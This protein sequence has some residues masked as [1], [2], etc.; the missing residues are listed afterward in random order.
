MEISSNSQRL[1]SFPAGN[2]N[3]LRYQLDNQF[4]SSVSNGISVQK[5]HLLQLAEGFNATY[6]NAMLDV[7]Y[8]DSTLE[9]VIFYQVG[10]TSIPQMYS[11]LLARI[12]DAGELFQRLEFSELSGNQKIHDGENYAVLLA[13]FSDPEWYS[14]DISACS[15]PYPGLTANGDGFIYC[16]NG[17]RVLAGVVDGL[18]HGEAAE[19]AQRLA[20]DTLQANSGAP[21]RELFSSVHRALRST[22]GAAM[23]LAIVDSQ[24][25]CVECAGVGNVELRM[26]HRQAN[27]LPTAGVLGMGTF[28]APVE[29]RSPWSNDSVL[30]MYSDGISGRWSMGELAQSSSSSRLMCH[31]LLRRYAK[32]N[33]DAT[34]LVI[35]GDGRDD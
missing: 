35:R 8:K 15:R 32:Q 25:G 3:A 30:V 34:V 33:D 13:E 9:S 4:S 2:L 1:I 19:E 21:L 31:M 20:L 29:R 28:K 18:G 10:G 16:Q 22:R 26:T 17:S 14:S 24:A 12:R 27:Y 23:T 6:P 11:P 5:Q 7:T